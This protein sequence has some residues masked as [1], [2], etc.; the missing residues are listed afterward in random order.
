MPS[1]CSKAGLLA[2]LTVLAVTGSVVT[3]APSATAAN[4][5]S[6]AP[7][8]AKVAY[9]VQVHNDRGRLEELS[10]HQ[11]WGHIDNRGSILVDCQIRGADSQTYYHLNGQEDV[12]ILRNNVDHVPNLATCR[13]QNAWGV[14]GRLAEKADILS[15]PNGKSIGY[16]LPHRVV[17]L[18]CLENGKY[19]IAGQVARSIAQNK[20]RK[21]YPE[22][23]RC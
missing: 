10:R 16:V 6:G 12:F 7:R 11:A 5:A 2:G 15:R 22:T 9:E 14:P 23:P 4:P 3:A 18:L 21:P 8:V 13:D 20:F 17:R 19:L 1:L